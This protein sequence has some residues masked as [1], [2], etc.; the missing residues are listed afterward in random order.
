MLEVNNIEVGT[1]QTNLSGVSA[2]DPAIF[3]DEDSATYYVFGTHFALA[4]SPDLVHWTQLA[5]DGE[6]EVLYGTRNFRSVLKESARLMGGNQNTWAPDVIKHGGKYYMYYTLTSAFGSNRSVIGRVEA[7]SVTGPYSGE[8][9][10]AV[11]EGNFGEPNCIDANLFYDR[12]GRLWMVYGSYFAGIFIKELFHDGEH[13]GLPMEDGFGKLLWRGN[14][15]E[16]PEGPYVFYNAETDYYYLTVSY[17]N[18][19]RNYNMRVA[20]SKRPD[21]PYV[22][23]TGADM[24]SILYGGNRLAGNYQF[25]GDAVGY[26][27]MGHN[28]VLKKDGNFF[29]VCHT[30][31]RKGAADVTGLH[32]VR[33]SRLFFNEDGW[34]LLSPA[35]YA[36]ESAPAAAADDVAG[37]YDV[38][39]HVTTTDSAVVFAQSSVYRFTA[40][41]KILERGSWSFQEGYVTLNLSGTEYRGVA[42]IENGTLVISA[43]SNAGGAL[44]ARKKI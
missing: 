42:A 4:S 24:A 39:V 5:R 25:A 16:G 41:G 3:Y 21:G 32:H 2:H 22:D 15:K 27:A 29:C 26:A 9:V 6:A 23:I 30:R 33:V 13:F 38:I 34:P 40:D 44:W 18:L 1:M 35:C 20:R 28:S 43:T 8:K 14:M 37:Q 17:G 36:G 19:A 11:S 7:D 12:D 31:Y 10:L